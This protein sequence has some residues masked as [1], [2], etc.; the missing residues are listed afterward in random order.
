MR[1]I[2]FVAAAALVAGSAFANDTV[3]HNF[4]ASAPRGGVR[5]IIVEVPTGE[6]HVRNGAADRIA[7]AGRAERDVSREANRIR[8]Q[9]TVDDI[10]IEIY[11]SD[12][13]AIVRRTFGEH[14]RG[15]SARNNGDYAITLEVPPGVDVDVRTTAGEVHFEGSF[16]S[17]RTDLRAGEIHATLARASVRALLASVRVGEVHA[18]VGDTR[19]D[20]EGV[21]PREVHWLNPNGGRGM[22]DL[23]TT[24]GE[25]HVTLR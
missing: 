25:V 13:E 20:N 17:I 5:R 9:Q 16:G 3:I 24:A 8:A 1:S 15:W 19:F 22:V 2:F 11:R 21:F 18:D 23:H 12:D 10:G 7:V 6:V 4:T 14:A